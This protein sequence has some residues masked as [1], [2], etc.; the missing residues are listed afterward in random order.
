MRKVVDYFIV[1][2]LVHELLTG[3][4]VAELVSLLS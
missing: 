1:W 2:K 4:F 3:F